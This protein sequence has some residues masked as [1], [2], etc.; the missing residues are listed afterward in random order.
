MNQYLFETMKPIHL[1]DESLPSST[2]WITKGAPNISFVHGILLHWHHS[3][4]NSFPELITNIVKNSFNYF[5]T[6][7]KMMFVF[8]LH[9]L[10]LFQAAQ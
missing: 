8:F 4:L 10:T 1:P 6:K 5:L 3:G 2:K 9:R 7:A